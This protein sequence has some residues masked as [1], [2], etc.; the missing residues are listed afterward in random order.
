MAPLVPKMQIPLDINPSRPK[1]FLAIP[2]LLIEL[3]KKI[4]H[5]RDLFLKNKR[6]L[7]AER[8]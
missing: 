6:C 7:T 3:Q 2:F 8:K 5:K 4:P 1:K